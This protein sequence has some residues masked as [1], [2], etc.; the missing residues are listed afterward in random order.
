MKLY[1]AA[2]TA[3][4]LTTSFACDFLDIG[5]DCKWEGSAPSCGS[6]DHDIGYLDPAGRTLVDW[7]HESSLEAFCA[8]EKRNGGNCCAAYGKGCVSGYKRL[9][10]KSYREDNIGHH[11]G[12]VVDDA[13]HT[14]DDV[15]NDVLH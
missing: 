9:W 12:A 1:T 13:L 14:V 8:A 11:V 5:K 2:A 10:C 3:L 15:L 4:F 6:V 7:T